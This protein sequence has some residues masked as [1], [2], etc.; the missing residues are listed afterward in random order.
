MDSRCHH[1]V[2]AARPIIFPLAP[3]DPRRLVPLYLMA[4]FRD[5]E[6]PEVL[7]VMLVIPLDRLPQLRRAVASWVVLKAS[8]R[9][10]VEEQ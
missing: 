9:D 6:V 8:E 10:L 7:H 5:G 1:Q 2:Q 4:I 3:A